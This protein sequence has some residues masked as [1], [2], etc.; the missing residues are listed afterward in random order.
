MKIEKVCDLPIVIIDNIYD[1]EEYQK[2]SEELEY[3]TNA[4][5][6]DVMDTGGAW[7]IVDG[8]KIAL[9]KNRG[10]FLDMVYHNRSFSKILKTNRKIFSKDFV[11]KLIDNYKIFRYI[12]YSIKDTTLIQYYENSDYYDSH[13]DKATLTAITWFYK[14]PKAFIGGELGFENDLK[15]DC[16]DNRMV[17]F[18]SIL[19]HSVQEIQLEQSFSNK[20]YGRYSVTQFIHMS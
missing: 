8:E 1:T 13:Y 9:K 20:N 19:E 15:I 11:E 5:A 14:K 4:G 6:F 16:C 2:I 18:P 7:E 12:L 10:V 17:I 3:L